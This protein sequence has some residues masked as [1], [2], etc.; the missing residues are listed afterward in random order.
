MASIEAVDLEDTDALDLL[1]RLDALAHDALDA[2]EQFPPEQRIARGLGQ[3]V[4]RLVEEPLRLGLDRGAYPLRFGRDACLFG[5]LLG[6]QHFDRPAPAGNLGVAHRD[7]PFLRFCGAR[8]C[9]LRFGLRGRLLKRLLVEGDC[10]FH[11]RRLDHFL[12]VYLEL[13]QI[14]LACDA[15]LVYAA[16]GGDTGTLDLFSRSDLGLL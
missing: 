16:I 2:V 14:S 13:A 4:F 7:D 11:Q 10:L 3:H 6:Q 8:F 12:A 15:R 9:V 5:R 1:H